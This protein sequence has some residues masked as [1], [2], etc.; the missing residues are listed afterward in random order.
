MSKK[1]QAG[2][3]AGLVAIIAFLIILYI[4]IIPED[5]RSDLINGTS[6]SKSTTKSTTLSE[7]ILVF[8]H[9]GTLDP[10]TL[11]NR[12]KVLDSFNLRAD[13][14]AVV[15]KSAEAV[16]IENGWLRR[17]P[18]NFS[19]KVTDLGNTDNYVLAFDVINS[20]GRITVALNGKEIY[21]SPAPVGNIA[22]IIINKEDVKEQNSLILSV[23]SPG[24]AFWRLNEYDL[25]NVRVIADFVDVSTKEYKNFFIITATEKENFDKTKLNFVPDCLTKSVGPLKIWINEKQLNYQALPDCGTLSSIEFNSD[26]LK[27]GDNSIT[28]KA[29]DGNYFIDRVSIKADLKEMKYPF[30]YFELKSKDF[31]KVQNRTANVTLILQFPDKDRKQGELNV[32]GQLSSIDVENSTFTKNIN[33]YAE[34]GQNYIQIKPKT[35]MNIVDLTVKLEK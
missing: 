28:F 9:P 19:F 4:L 10:I 16:H 35:I 25:K 32:N 17:N 18:Y 30:Y 27:Q 29:E 14:G 20:Y 22:P 8:E 3:A 13:K 24:L 11:K 7:S 6:D 5:I 33:L 2:G 21:N 1:G 26:L 31:S 23:S 12:E 34:E 15:L